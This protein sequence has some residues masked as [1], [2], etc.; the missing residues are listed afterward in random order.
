MALNPTYYYGYTESLPFMIAALGV[1]VFSPALGVLWVLVHAPA[2]LWATAT[3]RVP[4]SQLTT[5]MAIPAR[6]I[7]EAILWVG[8]VELPLLARRWAAGWAARVAGS[9]STLRSAAVLAGGMAGMAYLWVNS[10]YWLVLPVWNWS[11]QGG[12]GANV[13]LGMVM[14]TLAF[15]WIVALAVGAIAFVAGVRMP[16][17]AVAAGDDFE[18][19]APRQGLG[20]E[21][22]NVAILGV[23]LSGLMLRPSEA[24]KPSNEAV[25]ILLIVG[26]LVVAGPVLTRLLPRMPVPPWVTGVPTAARWGFAFFTSIGGTWLIVS[27]VP[28][29]AL[30]DYIL[31]AILFAIMAPLV[32][33]IVDAGMEPALPTAPATGP[34]SILGSMLALALWLA[35]PVFVLGHD[36]SPGMPQGN[37]LGPAAL[38]G[39]AA[40]AAAGGAAQ[41]KGK[42]KDPSNPQPIKKPKPQ[43][44]TPT[45]T[46]PQKVPPRGPKPGAQDKPD[47]PNFWDDP[48]GWF[49]SKFGG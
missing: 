27:L 45:P 28:V 31:L 15:G 46:P 35:L 38:M 14:G 7:G 16:A 6:L 4:G 12:P 24:Q 48:R 5:P 2:D 18:R 1:G 25:L 23:L 9:A 17:E 34:A 32:R 49:N 40:A 21:L 8:V 20:R 22:L 26:G 44:P 36:E 3:V 41:S 13:P 47:G 37:P 30:P 43:P 10:A 33:V 19:P 11:A 39:G 29:G 42:E